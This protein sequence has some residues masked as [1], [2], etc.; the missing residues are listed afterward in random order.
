MSCL[1]AATSVLDLNWEQLI[2]GKR[3]VLSMSQE[4][5]Q[6][7]NS[8]ADGRDIP[9]KVLIVLKVNDPVFVFGKKMILNVCVDVGPDWLYHLTC[10]EQQ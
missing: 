7:P 5:Y 8:Q 2:T 3:V 9:D 4:K 6:Q 10:C 1:V